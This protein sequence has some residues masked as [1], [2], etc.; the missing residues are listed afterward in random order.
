MTFG[1]FDDKIINS[2]DH[3]KKD[4][5]HLFH[6]HLYFVIALVLIIVGSIYYFSQ[7]APAA[8]VVPDWAWA[9]QFNSTDNAWTTGITKD[10]AGNSYVVGLFENQITI[11]LTP[12]GSAGSGVHMFVAKFDKDGLVDETFT[13]FSIDVGFAK[14]KGPSIAAQIESSASS[15]YITGAF[16]GTVDFDPSGTTNDLTSLGSS[17]IFLAQYNSATGAFANVVLDTNSTTN[18]DYP[19]AISLTS[20]YIYLADTI[21]GNNSEKFAFVNV[22]DKSDLNNQNTITISNEV[23]EYIEPYGIV[24]DNSNN[25]YVTGYIAGREIFDNG[26]SKETILQNVGGRDIYIAKYEFTTGPLWQLSWVKQYGGTGSLDN[27]QGTSLALDSAGEPYL[28]GTF[29]GHA[30]ADEYRFAGNFGTNCVTE[31]QF[32]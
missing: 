26:G 19:N 8:P 28:T 3:V 32:Q 21:V 20:D 2:Y 13:P 18:F 15:I 17:D 29:S 22:I 16:N 31:N 1:K 6:R 14:Y 5:A 9:K 23:K 7:R 24:A 10:N 12:L 30:E 11:G 25:F 4:F 27:S